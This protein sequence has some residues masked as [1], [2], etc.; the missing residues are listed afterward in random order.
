MT[1][2]YLIRLDDAH[3]CMNHEKWVRVE[4]ICL[5]YNVKPIIAVIPDNKDESLNYSSANEKFWKNLFKRQKNGWTIAL[6]G[7]QHKLKPSSKGL[8]P[9]NKYSEFVGVSA[10]NQ[11][12]MIHEGCRILKKYN[13]TPSVWVAPAHS[14]DKN[15]I[16]SLIS[17]SEIRTISDGFSIRPFNKLGINWI[18]QQ[19]W[20]GRD[21]WF[22]IWTI[23]LHPSEMTEGQIDGFMKFIEKNSKKIVNVDSLVFYRFSFIDYIFHL[24]FYFMLTLKKA[25]SIYFRKKYT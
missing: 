10:K 23:C 16:K 18:P 11:S 9:I 12:D 24:S 3:P 22:G 19:L 2:K 20:K 13:L 6:H 1:A 14:F 21:M 7:Y 17:S 5:K 15:T 25:L 4:S 8:V